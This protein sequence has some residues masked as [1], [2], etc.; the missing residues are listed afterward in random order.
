M[1]LEQIAAEKDRNMALSRFLRYRMG[2]SDA[3]I[4]RLKANNALIVSGKAVHAD[5]RLRP[6]EK[7]SVDLALAEED[8][9][10]VPEEGPLDILFEDSWFLAVN[11]PAGIL[12]HPSPV[13]YKGTLLNYA[14]GYLKA[15]V[16]AVNRLDRDTSGIVLLAKSA[17][18][19]RLGA[20]AM[21]A[22]KKIYTGL[23]YGS[24]SPETG[25]IDLPIDRVKEAR[26]QKREVSP[27]GQPAATGYETLARFDEYSRLRFLLETG[28]THQI[29]VH[30]SH[31]GHPILGDRLYGTE[32][33]QALSR[34]LGISRQQLHAESLEFTHPQNG[35]LIS[36]FAPAPF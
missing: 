32:A 28:R 29:R 35:V 18:A 17:H 3:L 19:M 10:L 8:T 16:H 23:V 5:Y 11:K 31:L 24:F 26:S 27:A 12:T 13:K 34:T 14:A 1:L 30:C 2:L 22:G 20:E 15:P 4:K 6:G 36:V 7:V 9:A 21:K 33:S 25:R